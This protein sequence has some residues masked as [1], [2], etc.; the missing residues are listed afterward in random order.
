MSERL[1]RNEM[2]HR[3]CAADENRPNT[4]SLTR[5]CFADDMAI[6]YHIEK[7]CMTTSNQNKNTY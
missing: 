3:D 6:T 4:Q 1:L 7:P 5:I 2:V